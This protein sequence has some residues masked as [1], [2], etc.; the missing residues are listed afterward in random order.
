VLTLDFLS[1]IG[2]F[3]AMLHKGRIKYIRSIPLLMLAGYHV[4]HDMAGKH[5]D[6]LYSVLTAAGFKVDC[7]PSGLG[8]EPL[9]QQLLIDQ[10][11][12]QINKD[13]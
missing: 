12:T 8:N 1:D 3:I 5:Q 2:N 11:Q 6:S 7:V 13:N 10:L 4:F 9:I